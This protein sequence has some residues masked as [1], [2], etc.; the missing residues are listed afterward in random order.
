MW[1]LTHRR[2][3]IRFT[4]GSH[5]KIIALLSW[6]KNGFSLALAETLPQSGKGKYQYHW[7]LTKIEYDIREK[8]MGGE[9]EKEQTE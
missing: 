5:R 3:C 6:E 4:E 7:R 9:N 8:R 2:R 1:M